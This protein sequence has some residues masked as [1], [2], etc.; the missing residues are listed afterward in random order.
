M[1]VAMTV[2]AGRT[3]RAA[4]LIALEELFA[5]GQSSYRNERVAARSGYGW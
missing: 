3:V 5:R 4:A 2:I 1:Y